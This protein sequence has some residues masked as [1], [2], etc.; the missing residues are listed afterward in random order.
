MKINI[1]AHFDEEAKKHEELVAK[2]KNKVEKLQK[3][4]ALKTESKVQL[5]KEKEKKEVLLLQNEEEGLDTAKLK[6]KIRE[7]DSQIAQVKGELAAGQKAI[8]G[9]DEIIQ[10]S[11]EREGRLA[12]V[13]KSKCECE[14]AT[15]VESLK[16]VFGQLPVVVDEFDKAGRPTKCTIRLSAGNSKALAIKSSGKHF[17]K[18][19]RPECLG[20]LP[21]HERKVAGDEGPSNHRESVRAFFDK[22]TT[23]LILSRTSVRW[24]E[25]S[26]RPY[27]S[28]GES[29]NQ[30][31]EHKEDFADVA[32][33]LEPELDRLIECEKGELD[34]NK[35]YEDNLLLAHARAT[36][37]AHTTPTPLFK[38]CSETLTS[39][40]IHQRIKADWDAFKNC[41]WSAAVS[42]TLALLKFHVENGE[43]ARF[44]SGEFE[45]LFGFR[46]RTR[47]HD[48]IVGELFIR[49]EEKQGAAK[50]LM[51]IHQRESSYN[52]VVASLGRLFLRVWRDRSER[53]PR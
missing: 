10:R 12:S 22:A 35:P 48:W 27:R 42:D 41:P 51:Q 30:V 32:T 4:I 19:F 40:E 13:L 14:E 18:D 1:K 23:K 44:W 7:L 20:W 8:Q 45:G 29:S 25:T 15:V 49:A 11:F 50:A 16:D 47:D 17:W 36:V 38:E 37:A 46:V 33:P 28:Y 3:D 43:K 26:E 39:D 6:G 31:I 34:L 21:L 53:Q 24:T 52:K 9:S 5:E 2:A